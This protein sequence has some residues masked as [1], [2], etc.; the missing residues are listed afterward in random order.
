VDFI[1][2]SLYRIFEEEFHVMDTLNDK[3]EA[4]VSMLILGGILGWILGFILIG[5]LWLTSNF[6]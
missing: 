4:Y 5:A 2:A 6:F 1:R 3:R